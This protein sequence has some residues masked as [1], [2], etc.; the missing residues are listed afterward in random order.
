VI[1]VKLERK[2]FRKWDWTA[3]IS[4]IRLNKFGRARSARTTA[5]ERTAGD[6]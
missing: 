1:W 3:Q 6:S 4:L 5:M 2:C